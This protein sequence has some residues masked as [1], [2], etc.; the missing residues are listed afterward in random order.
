[1][2]A[3]IFD[4][5]G[6]LVDSE[7]YWQEGFLEI[8]KDFCRESGLPDPDLELKDMARFQ[9]GRVNDTMRTILTSLGHEDLADREHI[10][11]LARRVID[12]VSDDFA[13][14]KLGA[15]TPGPI[16]QNVRVAHELADRGFPLAVASSSAQEFIEAALEQIGLL[17][18]VAVT[19]SAYELEHGKPHPEVYRRTLDRLG[20]KA[21]EAVAI[22]DSTTGIGSAVRAELAT[23]WFLLDT[24]ESDDD[25]MARL[26]DTLGEDADSAER[27]R[28]VTHELRVADIEEV[29]TQL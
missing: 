27:V 16:E 22:E 6:V 5:D 17:D 21:Q 20:V 24:G 1:M 18:A 13:A 10:E 9:G 3:V 26:R 23:I 29:M 11:A 25:A 8:T 14:R 7:P 4:L 12:R 28:L 2:M 15:S 19:Q